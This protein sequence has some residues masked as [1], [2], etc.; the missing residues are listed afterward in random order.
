MVEPLQGGNPTLSAEETLTQWH[1]EPLRL[2][3][4]PA[5]VD[6]LD[7]FCAL[8]R[9]KYSTVRCCIAFP[10]VEPKLGF[11]RPVRQ[12]QS[13]CVV[14]VSKSLDGWPAKAVELHLP[15]F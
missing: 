15:G 8:S 4:S 1:G 14:R 7:V 2:E 12:K 11:L 9:P 6:G 5:V 3:I 10:A 13:S